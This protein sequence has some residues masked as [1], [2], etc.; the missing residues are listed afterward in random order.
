M[1]FFRSAPA[2]L[3]GTAVSLA[4]LAC[5]TAAFAADMPVKAPVPVIGP[6]VP[7]D[8][9]GNLDIT[10]ATS[11]V[12][13]GGLLLYP[14]SGTA[15]TQINGGLS[16]DIFKNPAGFINSVS[17]H[18]GVWNE[19]RVSHRPIG[20]RAW[21]EMD[22][23]VGVDVGFAQYWKLTAE[24]VQFNFPTP[25]PP[26]AYNSVYTLGYDDAHL[27]W[28]FP[29]NPYVSLFYNMSGGSTVVFGKTSDTYRVTFGIVPTFA[30]FKEWVFPLTLQFPTS[31]TIAPK[32]FYNRN[33]GTTNACGV[34][35]LAPCALSN[36]GVFTTGIDAKWSLASVIP[37][38][39]G[40]WY[41]K[42]SGHYYRIDN[43]ALLAAQV[44]TGAATSFINAKKDVGIGS[45]SL[46][47][48]F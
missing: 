44:V 12:T 8:V 43:D 6:S 20:V 34:T 5:S 38:R 30:L 29:F 26:T 27:G 13:G 11:R 18:G 19:W 10:V 42:A 40:N 41:F 32:S 48:G 31:V 2:W 1:P 25:G 47:M 15:L 7:L 22:S 37:K 17:V 24:Y 35:G 33:D 36:F 23:Y 45:V 4:G 39:L 21:Q 9:H 14:T 46:G 16:F 3:V 28:W